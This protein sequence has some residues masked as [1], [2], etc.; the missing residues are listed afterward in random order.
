MLKVVGK[1]AVNF[2][3]TS[4]TVFF[5]RCI[6]SFSRVPMI[7]GVSSAQGK[8]IT[9]SKV[10][11]TSTT[12]FSQKRCASIIPKIPTIKFY[13]LRK[14]FAEMTSNKWDSGFKKRLII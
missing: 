10:P 12:L 5:Q 2:P 14:K 1:Y 11:E 4:T 9:V 6:S 7:S 13:S 8:Y 3:T